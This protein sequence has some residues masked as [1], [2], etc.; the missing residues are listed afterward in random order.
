MQ[1]MDLRTQGLNANHKSFSRLVYK[2]HKRIGWMKGTGGT[3][4]LSERS[5]FKAILR[6]ALSGAVWRDLR[7]EC[8]G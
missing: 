8:Y 3:S 6:I 7:E 5:M 2:K 1:P 4:K